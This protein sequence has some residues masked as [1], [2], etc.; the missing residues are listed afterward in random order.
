MQLQI[1]HVSVDPRVLDKRSAFTASETL[2]VQISQPCNIKKP[3]FLL[4]VSHVSPGYN[5]A[6][7]PAWGVYYFLGEPTILDGVRANVTGEMD[8]LTTYADGIKSLYGYLIRTADDTK[9]NKFIRDNAKQAQANRQQRTYQFN[10]SPFT[11]NFA[12]DIVYLLTVIGGGQH[13]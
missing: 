11:A 13:D 2:N 7:A 5:Y 3:T 10:R 12:Q 9:R 6:Y 1:G 4:D 8:Y